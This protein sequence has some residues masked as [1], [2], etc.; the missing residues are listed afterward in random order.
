MTTTAS[1]YAT[2]FPVLTHDAVTQGHTD[3]CAERG[4]ATHTVGEVVSPFCPRCGAR[5]EPTPAEE[6]AHDDEVERSI[7]EH[8]ESLLEAAPAANAALPP[9][10]IRRIYV[11]DRSSGTYAYSCTCGL[12]EGG[13]LVGPYATDGWREAHGLDP[14]ID[15]PLV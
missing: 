6:A 9:G 11:D 3:Y 12:R 5:P 8:E 14:L 4:H 15:Y 1:R 10:H 13:Y 2:S 7:A